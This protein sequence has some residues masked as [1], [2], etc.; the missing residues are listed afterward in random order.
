VVSTQR[1]VFSMHDTIEAQH[2]REAGMALS[3]GHLK[4]FIR[5]N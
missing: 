3:D 1:V 2:H 4:I 5:P